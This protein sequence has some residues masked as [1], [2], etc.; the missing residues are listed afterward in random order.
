MKTN[1]SI[2]L[3][4]LFIGITFN[5]YS[6]ERVT[7]VQIN[8]A[9]KL[10]AKKVANEMK[11][12]NCNSKSTPPAVKLPFFDDF[13]ISHVFPN[14][15]LWDGRSTFVNQDFGYMPVNIG[16]VTFDAIDSSGKVYS[17]ATVAPFEADRLLSQNIRLDSTFGLVD[18][19]LRPVDSVYLSFFYQPQGVGY[20]PQLK[21]SLILEFSRYTG[22]LIFSRVDSVTVSTKMY[23]GP[24]DTIFALTELFPP[25]GMGCNPEL[26]TTVY[27]NYLYGDSLTLACDSV[28]VPEIVWDMMWFSEGMS[29]EDFNEAYNKDMVQVMIPIIDTNYFSD[30]FRFRFRNYASM[31]GE[32]YPNTWNSNDDTWNVDYVYLNYNRFAGDTTYRALAF[33]Q[34]APSFL[35]DYQAMPYRQYRASAGNNMSDNLRLYISNLDNIEHN[36][37]YSYHAKPVGNYG[38]QFNINYN[39]G[40]CNLKPFYEFGFQ[41]CTDCGASHA[42]P[43]LES[44]FMINENIDTL[45]YIIKHYISDSSDQTSIVDSAI[46]H[47]YLYN[48]YAYDDGTPEGGWGVDGT[49]GGTVAYQ[50]DLSTRDTLWGVQ[51]YFNRTLHNANELYFNLLVW[52][53]NNNK[54]GEIIYTQEH[55]KVEWKDGLYPFYTYMFDE[56]QVL[57]GKFYVGW[58][59]EG[60]YKLNIGFDANNDVSDKIFFMEYN[61]WTNATIPGALLVRP[62]VGSNMILSTQ[63]LPS[64]NTINKI[65]VYPNPASTYFSVSEGDYSNDPAAQLKIFNIYGAEVLYEK[66]IQNKINISQLP[67]GI[68]VVKIASK[69][70]YYTA[71]LLINR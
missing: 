35:R 26:S 53:D 20:T 13:S 63:Q 37:R 3:I 59:R 7:G 33:S 14:Q 34:R 11:S 10:E 21:D 64:N 17:T 60:Q 62:I 29:L 44:S 43:P 61:D 66:G 45:S 2:L 57:A 71:K 70:K 36:T 56:P 9:V 48:F 31:L 12:C 15:E 49:S 50:F 69:N 41:I 68:Y 22:K 19:K 54:P 18:R 27:Q 8:E 1:Y 42:C 51:M 67:S 65:K 32:N 38:N 52:S 40:S 16:V 5:S 30:K 28:F 23:I 47:Q 6:Q 24:N 4:L 55:E 39:G 58:E 25:E 46:F